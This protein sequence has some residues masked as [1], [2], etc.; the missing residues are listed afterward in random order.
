MLRVLPTEGLSILTKLK[1]SIVR[2]IC[3]TILWTIN[4]QNEKVNI[5]LKKKHGLKKNN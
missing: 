5:Q 2:L 1:I 4:K 3:T